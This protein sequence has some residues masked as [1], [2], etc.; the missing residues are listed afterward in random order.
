MGARFQFVVGGALVQAEVSEFVVPTDGTPGRL[1]WYGWVEND[2]MK[3]IDA[4]CGW[5]IEDLPANRVRVVWK[6][7]LNG[8]AAQQMAKASSNPAVSSHQDWVEGIAKAA[9]AA[10]A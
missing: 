4:Y 6:E 5:L 8:P 10:C 2:G 3:I 9:L 7:T 1:S